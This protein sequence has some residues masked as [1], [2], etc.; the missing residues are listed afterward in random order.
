MKIVFIILTV[1]S[2]ILIGLAALAWAE[3]YALSVTQSSAI[4]LRA[5]AGEVLTMSF[6]TFCVCLGVTAILRQMD[7]SN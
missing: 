1:I 6:L 7:K 5:S 4:I 3:A 2:A